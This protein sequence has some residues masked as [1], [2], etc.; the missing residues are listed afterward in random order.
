MKRNMIDDISICVFGSSARA[1]TDQLSDLDVLVVADDPRTAQA[2]VDSWTSSGWSVSTYSRTRL[3]RVADAGSLFVK[4]LQQ[5]GRIASDPSGWLQNTLDEFKL[6]ECYR[7]DVEGALEL[8]KPLER[9]IQTNANRDSG[10]VADLS[11]VFMRNYGIYRCA[12]DGAYL[13]DYAA[14]LEELQGV[15]KF[16]DSCRNGLML[17]R[18]GKHKYRSGEGS[19]GD[20]FA[21][22]QTVD[23][24]MEACPNLHLQGLAR[25]SPVR[26]FSSQYATL[27]DCEA[28]MSANGL[29]YT[30]GSTENSEREAIWRMIKNPRD[31]SW[32]VHNIDEAWAAWATQVVFGT[33]ASQK[34]AS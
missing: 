23:W 15:E 16:S 26:S 24:L 3:L 27:R 10:L 6:K 1:N 9:F 28:A 33:E 7:S 2:T 8:A 20:S 5:E 30:G 29:S 18:E 12:V 14:I 17:L 32:H 4:H 13:F 31:Y 22:G 25:S 19:L 11:Y 34:L 21:I